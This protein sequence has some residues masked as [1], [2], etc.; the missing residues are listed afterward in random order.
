MT[1]ALISFWCLSG[2]AHGLSVSYA[3]NNYMQQMCQ[4]FTMDCV[5]IFDIS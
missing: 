1:K 4:E 5:M 3:I 2:S